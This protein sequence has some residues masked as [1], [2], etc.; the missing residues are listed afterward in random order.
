MVAEID[1]LENSG[2]KSEAGGLLLPVEKSLAKMSGN[3]YNE[4]IVEKP[5][6]ALC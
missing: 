5:S 1:G 6:P 2:P 4:S 3:V